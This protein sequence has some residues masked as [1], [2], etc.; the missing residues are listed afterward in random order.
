MAEIKYWLLRNFHLMFSKRRI[1]INN[2]KCFAELGYIYEWIE[3]E[4][5]NYFRRS[6][7]YLGKDWWLT[8]KQKTKI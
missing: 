2:G 4:Q 3:F 1:S 7:K 8:K 6:A 5:F